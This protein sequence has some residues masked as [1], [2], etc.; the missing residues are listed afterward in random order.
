MEETEVD[1][2]YDIVHADFKAAIADD[3][4]SVSDAITL[5]AHGL[6]MMDRFPHLS[7]D[8]RMTLLLRVL[9]DIAKG[10]DG[11]WGTDDDLLSPMVWNG[12][13]VL[14]EGGLLQATVRVISRIM[15]GDFPSING[16]EVRG[17]LGMIVDTIL[18]PESPRR[19]TS[20]ARGSPSRS[21]TSSPTRSLPSPTPKSPSGRAAVGSPDK[22]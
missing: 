2:I 7:V 11:L 17:C 12:V 14:I 6:Q 16:P 1:R 3:R 13:R 5:V 21:S 18:R 22:K 19:P 8:E 15:R 4:I 20:P 10:P 9:E